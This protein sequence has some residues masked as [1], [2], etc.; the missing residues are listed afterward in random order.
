[1]DGRAAWGE[2]ETACIINHSISNQRKKRRFTMFKKL[3]SILAAAVMTLAAGSAF[4]SFSNGDLIQVVYNRGG[5]VESVTDLGSMTSLLSGGSTNAN[6]FSL[7]SITGATSASDLYVAYFASNYVGPG[8]VNQ[9]YVGATSAPITG[10]RKYSTY[11]ANVSNLDVY[12]N[13]IGGTAANTVVGPQTGVNAYANLLGQTSQQGNLGGYLTTANAD[14]NLATLLAS[15][16]KTTIYSFTSQGGTSGATTG[17]ATTLVLDTTY[18]AATGIGST[19][20]AAAA[21][22]TPIPAA[23]YLLGSGLLGLF[24]IRRRGN[25]A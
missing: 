5:S 8:N 19:S 12:Y 24:G 2:I 11:N 6:T 18:N 14:Q 9:A 15:G 1:M 23:V 4:A 20:V 7:S 21:A 13:G 3:A 10:N 17:I 22:T 16:G 25:K